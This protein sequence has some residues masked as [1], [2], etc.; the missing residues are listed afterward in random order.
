MFEFLFGQYLDYP[1]SAILLESIAV[2]FGLLSVGLA[3]KDNIG[4]FPTGLISTGIYVYLLWKWSLLGDMLINVY[5]VI[6]SI[7]GW[8][9]WSQKSQEEPIYP[10]SFTTNQERY[11]SFLLFIFSV[12]GV[13]GVYFVFNK[14][15]NWYSYLDTLITGIFF[16]GMWLMAKRKIENWIFWI[17]GDALSIPL[18]FLKGYTLTSIQ[19]LIFTVVAIYGYRAWINKYNTSK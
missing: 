12:V 11:F 1:T 3:K 15:T 6:M 5:Y 2:V 18:Y 8:I 14:F 19:Y 7:Y 10:I 17:I 4:V 13:I 9:I 16:V